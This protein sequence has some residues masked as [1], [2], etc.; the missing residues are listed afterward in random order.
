[1]GEAG[2]G[3]RRRELGEGRKRKL[4]LLAR[5]GAVAAGDEGGKLFL[6]LLV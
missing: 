1:M 6:L 3:R 2:A 4:L 5:W